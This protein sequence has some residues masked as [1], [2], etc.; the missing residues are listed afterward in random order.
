M[1]LQKVLKAVAVTLVM[2]ASLFFTTNIIAQPLDGWQRPGICNTGPTDESKLVVINGLYKAQIDGEVIENIH[3]KGEIQIHANNVTI[4]NFIADGEK[5]QWRAINIIGG[6]TGLVLEDGIIRNFKAE[7]IGY[8]ENFTAR[9][10]EIYDSEGD[11]LKAGNNSTI[12]S[13]YIHHIGNKVGAHADGVQVTGGNNI[14]FIGNYISAL[15]D[16]SGDPAVPPYQYH[17]AI[18]IQCDQATVDNVMIENNW[19]N[20]GGNIIAGGPKALGLPT[21]IVIKN[22][23]IGGNFEYN[24]IQ[25]GEQ[26]S[27][28]INN[29]L[30]TKGT[31]TIPV[32]GVEMDIL[33][34][35]VA[36]TP[37]SETIK[38]GDK[39]TLLETVSPVN[40]TD[41]TVVWS[42]SNESIATVTPNGLVTAIGNGVVEIKVTTNNGG[43]FAISTITVE[44][45]LSILD[46]DLKSFSVYPNPLKGGYISIKTINFE[47]GNANISVV[48]VSGR[49][50]IQMQ[51]SIN[52][53]NDILMINVS[54]LKKGIYFV[55]VTS[56]SISDRVKFI[57]E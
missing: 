28:Q 57:L 14:K 47:V 10:L 34:T 45:T 42:S 8:P 33:V 54:H 49:E 53:K 32:C 31:N 41:K 55:Q 40:A 39:I 2:F 37:T 19:L 1:N 46:V 17:D 21:N 38:V 25:A 26:F 23:H 24:H 11:G 48:D 22:N 50:V 18:I 44:S 29:V 4:R 3:V 52:N 12:E 27:N 20:N 7:A 13:C 56:Q 43:H 51:T 15:G 6:A 36:V 9:R 30:D 35:G 16:G 5:E